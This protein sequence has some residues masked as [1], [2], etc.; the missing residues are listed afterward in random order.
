[1]PEMYC[2]LIQYTEEC[3]SEVLRCIC[4][5]LPMKRNIALWRKIILKVLN[6]TNKQKDPLK[7]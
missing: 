3:F 5:I 6:Q 4:S 7:C 2:V 1:M